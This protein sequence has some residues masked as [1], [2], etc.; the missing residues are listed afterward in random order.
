MYMHSSMTTES[1]DETHYAVVMDP[2]D[3]SDV[4]SRWL[5]EES[6][7]ST[8]EEEDEEEDAEKPHPRIKH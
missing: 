6:E 1:P 4:W 7:S 8:D 2:E 5:L 3:G